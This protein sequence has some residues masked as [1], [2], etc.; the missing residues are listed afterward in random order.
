MRCLGPSPGHG[1]RRGLERE[2]E[3]R[4]DEG[5]VPMDAPPLACRSMA[6]S[7]RGLG[8]RVHVPPLLLPLRGCGGGWL[9]GSGRRLSS[10]S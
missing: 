5:F 6:S 2:G 10:S 7:L 8:F 3:T 4:E 1:D 9:R